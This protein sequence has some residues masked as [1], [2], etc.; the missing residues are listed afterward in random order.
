MPSPTP[1]VI[2]Y[3]NQDSGFAIGIA[4]ISPDENTLH[5][6]NVTTIVEHSSETNS[7]TSRAALKKPSI[8]KSKP[9]PP[10]YS[11]EPPYPLS[12]ETRY[13]RTDESHTQGVV[14]GPSNRG[15]AFNIH[16][17][18]QLPARMPS[19]S[20]LPRS[21]ISQPQPIQ[22][23]PQPH[24]G[25]SRREVHS[26]EPP[27]LQ[28]RATPP[29]PR[30]HRASTYALG[31]SGTHTDRSV[32]ASSLQ[33]GES[34]P[35]SSDARSVQQS[36]VTTSNASR[37][38]GSSQT[39]EDYRRNPY[40]PKHLVMPTPL[41]P[42]LQSQAAVERI[43]LDPRASPIHP[44]DS[45]PSKRRSTLV[46]SPIPRAENIPVAPS[47]GKLR[48]RMSL[49]GGKKEQASPVAAVSFLANIVTSDKNDSGAEKQRKN[50]LNKRK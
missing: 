44:R 9:S 13:T 27:P 35:R 36:L 7:S 12:N 41:Q 33:R 3:D 29:D 49:L 21:G 37:M 30:L 40:L 32:F 34:I 4:M 38:T 47:G 10:P 50:V 14:T 20:S 43:R 23:S 6:T 2:Q 42:A 22:M 39:R 28:E 15:Q 17:N 46:T 5:P 19:T 48:K 24:S 11:F 8:D 45:S 16:E 31:P 1:T 18:T 26:L 25:P